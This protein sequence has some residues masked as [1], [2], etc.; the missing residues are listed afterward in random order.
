MENKNLELRQFLQ[1][2]PNATKA[3]ISEGI[4]FKGLPLFNLLKKMVNDG[5]IIENGDTDSKTFSL[6]VTTE[7]PKRFEGGDETETVNVD[8]NKEQ[9]SVI[10]DDE[11]KEDVELDPPNE[12]KETE[13]TETGTKSGRD[14]SK[15]KFNGQEYG[16]GPL[17]RAVV[18]KYAEDNADITF[19]Q[20]KEAFPDDLLKRFGIFQDLNEAKT[21]GGKGNRYFSKPEQVI[22]LKDKSVVV[23]NQFTAENIKPFLAK[24]KELGYK[25]K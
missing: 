17:V 16:K 5:T 25:I 13:T 22:K 24:V 2:N 15:F 7:K 12:N 3:Q 4:D 23:C 1:N 9:S 11:N 10:A 18:T 19:A 6:V 14:N 8:E 21:I 20:L